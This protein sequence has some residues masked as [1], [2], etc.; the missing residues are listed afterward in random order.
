MVKEARIHWIDNLKAIG[1]IFII[2]GHSLAYP[3][4]LLNYTYS[5]HVPLF[6]FIGGIN[7]GEN[8]IKAGFKVFLAKMAKRLLIP[9]IFFNLI[10]YFFWFFRTKIIVENS[11]TAFYK[12][13]I[14]IIYGIGIEDWLIHNTPL[15]F[16]PCL[17]ICQIFLFILLKT[18]R[19]SSVILIMLIISGLAGYLYSRF[20]NYR[21]PWGIDIAFTG[22]VFLGLGYL[23]KER[24]EKMFNR[25]SLVFSI[26]FLSLNIIF[27]ILNGRIDMNYNRYNNI[28]LFYGAAFSGIF[29]WAIFSM[30]IGSPNILKYI[31]EN[32]LLFFSMHIPILFI[33]VQS[34]MTLGIPYTVQE[35]NLLF[36][37][38]HTAMTLLFLSP[39]VFF[40]NRYLNFIYGG[41]RSSNK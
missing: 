40:T 17:F 38:I 26:I 15:W 25:K 6:F 11:D 27:V 37:F 24:L 21:L 28:F 19:K 31:G 10:S 4:Y 2:L 30:K 29:F 18:F 39:A 20:F 22:T 14:G 1:L 3:K 7:F 5:F 16:L 12:P 36:S 41:G 34:L 32:S 33:V 8:N 13:L 23:L 35:K 9:Y